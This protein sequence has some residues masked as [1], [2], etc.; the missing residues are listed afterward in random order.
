MPEYIKS[1]HSMKA[2]KYTECENMETKV[3]RIVFSCTA[4]ETLTNIIML[5][6][7]CGTNFV[8]WTN[9]IFK[10][11]AM[12]QAGRLW[13]LAKEAWV[14]SRVKPSEIF[15][16]QSGSGRGISTNTSVL[17]CCYHFQQ[18]FILILTLPVV[19]IRRTIGRSLG[20]FQKHSKIWKQWA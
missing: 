14:L 7:L 6:L 12:V 1:L 5:C 9:F 18:C 2:V 8:Y 17:P 4:P 3:N 11:C 15:G 20:N 10:G 19:P 13:P 16:G